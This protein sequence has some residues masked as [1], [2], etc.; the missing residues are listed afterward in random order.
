MGGVP[1]RRLCF[2]EAIL[3]AAD[4][5]LT[6]TAYVSRREFLQRAAVLSTAP[7][8]ALALA[9]SVHA[10]GSDAIKVGLVGCGGRGAGAA[11]NAMNAGK[12]CA[13]WR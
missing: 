9:R 13:W 1:I 3:M 6:R 7:C 5:R 10:A 2:Q 4:E 12:T 11:A 8:G